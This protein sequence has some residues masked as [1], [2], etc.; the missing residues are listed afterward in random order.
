MIAT[1]NMLKVWDPVVRGGHW[2]LA[3]AFFIAYLTEDDFL[4]L[5][6]W[7]GYLVASILCLRLLWGLVGSKHAKFKDF[8]YSPAITLQYIR[9]LIGG[10]AKRFIGHNPAGGAMV[11]ALLFALTATVSS[12]LMLY[13]IEEN[14]GPL[15]EWVAESS[16]S[17]SKPALMS[18]AL[19]DEDRH[20]DD[21]R[22]EL[23][24]EL[25]ELFANLTLL[26]VGLHIAG[27]LFSSYAHKENLIKGMFT[28]RKRSDPD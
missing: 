13:A 28:G 26:L 27:V 16:E 8:V 1:E 4:T 6:V 15:A 22:E 9:D 20:N 10:H 14:A 12:G 23:W 7:A 18:R 24:E 5:H 19:A 2:L 17:F 25:H 11:L 3:I 21:S